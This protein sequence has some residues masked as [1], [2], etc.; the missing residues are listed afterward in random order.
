MSDFPGQE[1]ILVFTASEKT[2]FS[3][4]GWKV[5]DALILFRMFYI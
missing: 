1:V 2:T 3:P 4:P 5:V